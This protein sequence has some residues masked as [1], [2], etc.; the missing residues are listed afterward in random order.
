M[1]LIGCVKKDN[2]FYFMEADH[3]DFMIDLSSQE[4]NIDKFYRDGIV[5]VNDENI[6][7]YIRFV[8]RHK[9][10]IEDLSTDYHSLSPDERLESEASFLPT[11]FIDFDEK[12]FYSSHPDSYYLNFRDYLAQDWKYIELEDL[13]DLVPEEK[14]YWKGW[15]IPK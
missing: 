13:S 15:A 10:D 12:I 9:I 1:E 2:N 8:G 5:V 3:F 6:N 14:F 4:N 11:V 7:D